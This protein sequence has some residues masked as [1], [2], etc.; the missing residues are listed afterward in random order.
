MIRV[1]GERQP[2]IDFRVGDM[3]ALDLPDASLAGLI[4][5]YAIVHFEP[6]EL[7][8]VFREMRRVLRPGA[9]ALLAFHVGDEVVHRD[10]LFGAPVSLDFRFHRPEAVADALRAAGLA[11]TERTDREP[12]EGAEH[13]SRRCYLLARAV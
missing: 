12:Y 3:R 2:G 9:P 5:F 8:P 7:E 1:A 10:E 13:P 11:P 4:A 6:T